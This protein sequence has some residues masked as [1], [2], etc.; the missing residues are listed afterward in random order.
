M[1]RTGEGTKQDITSSALLFR[2]AATRGHP[3]AWVKFHAHSKSYEAMLARGNAVRSVFFQLPEFKEMGM[4]VLMLVL[5]L[6][7]VVV[8]V[9]V[10]FGFGLVL[11]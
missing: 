7:G 4:L 11:V 1:P 3:Y 6:L 5:V 10:G 8:L 2:I 9:S